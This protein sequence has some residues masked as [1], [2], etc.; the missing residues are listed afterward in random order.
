VNWRLL[1]WKEIAGFLL[2]IG[3]VVVFVAFLSYANFPYANF[4]TKL[5][6]PP[7]F[8]PDWSCTYP[9]KGDPVCVTKAMPPN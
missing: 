4:P 1:T 8:G 7:G 6:A 9:G 2:V 5:Q 3:L